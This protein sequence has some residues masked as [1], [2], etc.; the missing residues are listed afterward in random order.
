[1][2]EVQADRLRN[3]FITVRKGNRKAKASFWAQGHRLLLASGVALILVA[4]ALAFA[5][6]NYQ[7]VQLGYTTSRLHQER[8]QLVEL[9]RKLK[10]ELANLTALDRLEQLAKGQL[11]LTPPKPEQI[12]VIE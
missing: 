11:G 2:A 1:M 8:G 12:Q 5:W 9:N 3:G 4:F 7:A 10:V 6:T